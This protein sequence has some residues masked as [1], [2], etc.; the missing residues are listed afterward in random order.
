MLAWMWRKR[1]TSPLLVVLQT[2]VQPLWKSVWGFLRKLDIVVLEDPAIPLLA[3]Y[4]EDVSTYNEDTCSTMLL[5]ALFVIARS[6]KGHR[7]PSTKEWIEKMWYIYTMEY[8]ASII[9]NE[10]MNS[11]LIR[12]FLHLHFQCYPQ[13][14]PIP[15]P[16]LLPYAP[17]PT[18]WPW[19]SSVLRHI[20]F[21]RPMGLYFH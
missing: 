7:C 21:A 17:T 20:K 13:K 11:F 10:F 2:V 6:W 18:S 4:P 3:I 9:I 8:Y 12:F 19:H 5:A 14:P 1:N 15:S 16:P